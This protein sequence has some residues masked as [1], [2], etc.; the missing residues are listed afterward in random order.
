MALI[1]EANPNLTWRDLQYI[2]LKTARKN[3]DKD[4]DWVTN[5]AG[6]SVNHKV[7]KLKNK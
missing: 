3:D 7:K 6:Y 5:G 2:L 1:L 4:P